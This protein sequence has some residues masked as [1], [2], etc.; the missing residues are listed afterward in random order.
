MQYSEA[1][2][3]QNMKVQFHEDM[4]PMFFSQCL[5][6]Y[7]HNYESENACLYPANT[8]QVIQNVS[9]LHSDPIPL[10]IPFHQTPARTFSLIYLKCV[11]V[12]AS[13]PVCL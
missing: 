12:C 6:L 13:G 2:A 4:D 5:C 9:Y 7:R 8:D 3:H 10:K 11:S 1:E